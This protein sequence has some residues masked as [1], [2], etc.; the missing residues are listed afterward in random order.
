[1]IIGNIA[2]TLALLEVINVSRLSVEYVY[3]F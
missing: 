3:V 1:M 2:A